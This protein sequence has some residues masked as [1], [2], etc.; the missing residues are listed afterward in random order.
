[1]RD[2]LFQ[3][4]EYSLSIMRSYLT[5]C[6]ANEATAHENRS[7]TR[8]LLKLNV[9]QSAQRYTSNILSRI[10]QANIC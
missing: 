8:S 3:S 7:T 6:N 9:T 4:A 2:H 5:V 10:S 1:M